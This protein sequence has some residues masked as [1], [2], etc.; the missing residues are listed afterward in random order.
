MLSSGALTAIELNKPD[1]TGVEFVAAKDE[2]SPPDLQPLPKYFVNE[3]PHKPQLVLETNF[4]CEEIGDW[5]QKL[6][7]NLHGKW[8]IS[9]STDSIAKQWK[10][11][12]SPGPTICGACAC[13]S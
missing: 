5:D 7:S 9:V 13:C 1:E 11:C 4:T 3:P 8:F 12:P 10:K 6:I 2:P